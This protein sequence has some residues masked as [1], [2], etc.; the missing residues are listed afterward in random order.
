MTEGSTS[1][2]ASCLPLSFPQELIDSIIDES[3]DDEQSLRALSLVDRRWYK[4]TRDHL[5]HSIGLQDPT[6]KFSGQKQR[7]QDGEAPCHRLLEILESRP[8]LRR[9]IKEFSIVSKTDSQ[10]GLC[11]WSQPCPTVINILPLLPAVRSFI[12][13]DCSYFLRLANLHPALRHAVF[14]FM[15]RPSVTAIWLRDIADVD[16][17]PIIQKSHLETLYLGNV[18][19]GTEFDPPLPP[20]VHHE[21][22]S[23]QDSSSQSSELISATGPAFLQILDIWGSGDVFKNIL[24]LTNNPD[25]RISLTRLRELRMGILFFDEAMEESWNT[26]LDPCAEH[27]EK[28][29]VYDG[30]HLRTPDLPEDVDP[31]PRSVF[32]FTRFPRLKDL[33]VVIPTRYFQWFDE[34]NVTPILL[35]ALEQLSQSSRSSSSYF[36]ETLK[37]EFTLYNSMCEWVGEPVSLSDIVSRFSQDG[38]L[39]KGLDRVLGNSDSGSLSAL[40]DVAITLDLASSDPPVEEEVWERAKRAILDRMPNIGNRI[41]LRALF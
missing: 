20:S 17:L 24:Q 16:I 35:E 11:G 10:T 28:Y 3:Q 22:A 6:T 8:L 30:G 40:E 18:H 36:L 37:I 4:R 13:V 26:F 2:G 5:F 38:T 25:T 33:K 34:H 7:E 31:F 9:S 41:N 27:V 12:L 1:S 15:S 39:W 29:V 19:F 32:A 23:A 14:N 21:A